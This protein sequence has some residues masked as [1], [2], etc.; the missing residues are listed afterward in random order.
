MIC[1]I[2]IIDHYSL[3]FHRMIVRLSLFN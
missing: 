2:D 3:S 1:I